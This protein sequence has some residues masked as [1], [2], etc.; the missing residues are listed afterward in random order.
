MLLNLLSD[1]TKF[2]K[3]DEIVTIIARKEG[4]MAQISVSDTRIGIK[5]ENIGKLFNE[6]EQVDKGISRQYHFSILILDLF[7]M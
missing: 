1:A 2:S 5:E 4:D 3:P 7:K 6:L